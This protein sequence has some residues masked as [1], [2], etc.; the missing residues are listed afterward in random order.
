M[1]DIGAVTN[2]SIRCSVK[3]KFGRVIHWQGLELVEMASKA[4]TI[5][6]KSD[7]EGRF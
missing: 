6:K 5:D 1:I 2:D 7:L 3:R 4:P